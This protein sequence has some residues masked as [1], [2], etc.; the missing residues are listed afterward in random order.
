MAVLGLCWLVF[1]LFCVFSWLPPSP[2]VRPARFSKTLERA[3]SRAAPR[4]IRPVPG[5][6]RS[7]GRSSLR[8]PC[9][10][11][12]ISVLPSFPCLSGSFLRLFLASTPGRLTRFISEARGCPSPVPFVERRS[13]MRSSPRD[14]SHR[15]GARAQGRSRRVS[16]RAVIIMPSCG[17]IQRSETHPQHPGLEGSNM[18]LAGSGDWHGVPFCRLP[19]PV[20]NHHT[21]PR[22]PGTMPIVNCCGSLIGLKYRVW[23]AKTLWRWPKQSTVAS[24]ALLP[25]A[26]CPR[27]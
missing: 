20:R 17:L 22:Q 23:Q 18:P 26:R 13:S 15:T 27:A 8:I 5:E 3:R 1:G 16:T 10:G 2:F 6:P 19:C 25:A 14:G 24:C 7:V 9:N 12:L 21:S 11:S 4:Q